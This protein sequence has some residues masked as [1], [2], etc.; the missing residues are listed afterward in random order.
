MASAAYP[1]VNSLIHEV[2]S[3]S[4]IL[5]ERTFFLILFKK[6]YTVFDYISLTKNLYEFYAYSAVIP[7]LRAAIAN[8]VKKLQTVWLLN[9]SVRHSM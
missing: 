4:N 7:S 9:S 5:S 8:E 3:I 1:L 6:G 2:H